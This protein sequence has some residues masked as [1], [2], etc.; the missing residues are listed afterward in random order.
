MSSRSFRNTF[1]V[2]EDHIKTALSSCNTPK[3]EFLIISEV[4]VAIEAIES[5]MTCQLLQNTFDLSIST[6]QVKVRGCFVLGN[7][8]CSLRETS[9]RTRVT[10]Y[11]IHNKGKCEKR[12]QFSHNKM[13]TSLSLSLSTAGSPVAVIQTCVCVLTFAKVKGSRRLVIIC[14]FPDGLPLKSSDTL[15]N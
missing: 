14:P 6:Y 15:S 5:I 11:G 2:K 7:N 8:V 4:A 9:G 3:I 10:G 12:G 13:V 1:S